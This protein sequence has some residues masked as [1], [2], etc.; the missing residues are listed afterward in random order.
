MT[1]GAKTLILIKKLINKIVIMQAE[2]VPNIVIRERMKVE[3][4]IQKS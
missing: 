2:T 4:V 3:E 1:Y